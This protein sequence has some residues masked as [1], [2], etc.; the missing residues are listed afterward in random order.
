[1]TTHSDRQWWPFDIDVSTDQKSTETSLKVSFLT[2]ALRPGVRPYIQ[3]C[4]L[5]CGA[6]SENGRECLIVW[7][8]KQRS[9]LLLWKHEQLM[10]KRGFTAIGEGEA[11]RQA[12]SVG[13][14]WLHDGIV[15][16][17]S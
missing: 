13:L 6:I 1:M 7:R 4:D 12:T 9:E 10:L 15:D 5:E 2:N 8:G 16:N 11:F 14:K 3:N 17:D